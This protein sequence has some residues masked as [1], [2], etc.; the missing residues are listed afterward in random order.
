MNRI[1]TIHM[2]QFLPKENRVMAFEGIKR[3]S[4]PVVKFGRGNVDPNA[5]ITENGQLRFNKALDEAIGSPTK[6]LIAF[7]K[8][9]RTIRV[10]ATAKPPKGWA[11]ED[12]MEVKRSKPD[13]NGKVANTGGYISAA[14]IW[15]LEH[16]AYDFR[17]SGQQNFKPEVS[18]M[19]DGTLTF[20][21]VVPKGSLPAQPKRER[22]ANKKAAAPAQAAA[23]GAGDLDLG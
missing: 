2:P 7:D 17:K 1:T 3:S 8:D 11:E 20:T 14:A 19:K 9:S 16:I 21:I 13:D 10:L 4:L 22:S 15:R 5:A 6:V 12:L 23:A 18:T